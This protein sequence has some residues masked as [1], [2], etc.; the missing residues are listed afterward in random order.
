MVIIIEESEGPLITANHPFLT[1][2]STG[3][4]LVIWV[5]PK[6]LG[7]PNGW[8]I[9]KN[10]IKMDDLGGVLPPL[11]LET[12]IYLGRLI[13][14]DPEIQKSYWF[15]WWFGFPNYQFWQCKPGVIWILFDS[16]SQWLTFWTFGDSIFSRENKVQTFF[17]RVHW[18]SEL[19]N[20]R[21]Y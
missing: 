15:T 1:T 3:F 9:M 17:F 4:A 12:T 8:F 2:C 19:K 20:Q 10:P 11:F 21:I 16:L 7:T 13:C 5:F 14:W 6:I 18:L